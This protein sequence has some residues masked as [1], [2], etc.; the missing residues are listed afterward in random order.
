MIGAL[1][2]KA[3]HPRYT[4][5]VAARIVRNARETKTLAPQHVEPSIIEIRGKAV[6]LDADLAALYDVL[7][8]ALNQAVKRNRDRFPADFMFRLTA[9]EAE[10][11]RR[12]R[13]QIV[14]LKSPSPF[15][16]FP[17][18]RSVSISVHQWLKSFGC[19][20]PVVTQ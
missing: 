15:A 18:V 14:T 8:K 10:E 3:R 11:L 4:Y 19:C 13:S 6:V 9:D 16:L 5:G 2:G 12:S 20:L 1:L 7:T 17:P